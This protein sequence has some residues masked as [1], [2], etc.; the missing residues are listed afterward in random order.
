MTVDVTYAQAAWGVTWTLVY[1]LVFLLRLYLRDG[2][3]WGTPE[4]PMT[5]QPSVSNPREAIAVF[6]SRLGSLHDDVNDMKSV[7]NF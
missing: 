1:L 7:L 3:V 5:M 4:E 2:G 6:N